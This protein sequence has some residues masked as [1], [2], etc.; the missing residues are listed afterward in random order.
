MKAELPNA[1]EFG[2]REIQ[3]LVGSAKATYG[4]L[5]IDKRYGVDRY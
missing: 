4:E 5:R 3:T 1:P 2:I